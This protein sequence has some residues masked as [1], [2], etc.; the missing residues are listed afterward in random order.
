MSVVVPVWFQ[1]VIIDNIIIVFFFRLQCLS[2]VESQVANQLNPIKITSYGRSFLSQINYTG[3]NC[4]AILNLLKVVHFT[5]V[6]RG[7]TPE[8]HLARIGVWQIH[9]VH[10]APP[11]QQ[12]LPL[13]LFLFHWFP[14]NHHLLNPSNGTNCFFGLKSRLIPQPQFGSDNI[15]VNGRI[16]KLTF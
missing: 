15:I 7:L 1:L 10:P 14:L 2:V 13:C 12:L 4:D 9:Q 5:L 11:I 8:T 16:Y 6:R 3:Q